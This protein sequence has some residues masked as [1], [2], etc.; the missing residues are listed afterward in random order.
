MYVDYFLS[1]KKK[2][3]FFGWFFYY[4]LLKCKE[5]LFKCIWMKWKFCCMNEGV[6]VKFYDW[7]K[8][9]DVL[10]DIL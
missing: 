10:R 5:I 8:L 7:V 4:E 3:K 2:I 6:G 1:M 9:S